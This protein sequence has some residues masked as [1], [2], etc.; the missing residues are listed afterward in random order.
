M[1]QATDQKVVKLLAPVS[2]TALTSAELDTVQSG[3][4]SDYVCIYYMFGVIG[5]GNITAGNFKLQHS[6]TSGSG[7]TDI[8][9]TANTTG[10][11]F[12][13]VTTTT[14]DGKIYSINVDTRKTK[15]FLK[16]TCTATAAT[17][18]CAWAILDRM[19]EA[20]YTAATRGIT[21]A[22]LLI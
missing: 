4:K 15:R 9:A 17:L 21:G 14:D 16:V 7:F 1:I 22:E 12:G 19:K 8:A 5:A 10:G 3:I 20:P 18:G 11:T 13:V 2:G 6:D